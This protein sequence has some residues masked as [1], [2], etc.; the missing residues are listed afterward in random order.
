MS[1]NSLHLRS[2]FLRASLL[3]VFFALDGRAAGEGSINSST[4]P[5]SSEITV[6][7][8]VVI[9]GGAVGSTSTL[10]IDVDPDVECVVEVQGRTLAG[11]VTVGIRRHGEA[12]GFVD[13]QPAVG[14]VWR[15]KVSGLSSVD[16]EF[17]SPGAFRFELNSIKARPAEQA[18]DDLPLSRVSRTR[19]NAK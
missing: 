8:H 2:F 5:H 18:G 1:A 3:V 9:S 13:N 10:N 12:R 17:H 16:V 7:E 4:L 15:W 11:T 6:Y 19:E 14:S